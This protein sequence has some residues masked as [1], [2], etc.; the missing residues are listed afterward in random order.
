MA[1]YFIARPLAAERPEMK[2]E[3]TDPPD[4]A[5]GVPRLTCELSTIER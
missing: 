1:A 5:T 2:K 4:P 3:F